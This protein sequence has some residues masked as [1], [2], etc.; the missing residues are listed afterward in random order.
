MNFLMWISFWLN[1][2]FFAGSAALLAIVIVQPAVGDAWIS[3]GVSYSAALIISLWGWYSS[4]NA[5]YKLKLRR[6]W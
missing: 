3:E 1:L 4:V 2:I 5:L 6:S